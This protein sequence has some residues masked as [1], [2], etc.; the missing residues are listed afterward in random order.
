MKCIYVCPCEN[1]SVLCTKREKLNTHM[2][3]RER[4]RESL[5]DTWT[6]RQI[7]QVTQ[8]RE[9]ERERERREREKFF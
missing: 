8:E 4:E 6:V 2:S 7:A 3:E 1:I 5:R 9:R